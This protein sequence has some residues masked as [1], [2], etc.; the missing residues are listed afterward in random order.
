MSKKLALRYTQGKL[1]HELIPSEFKEA[2]AKVYTIGAEK[3]T[4][5]DEEGKVLEDGSSNW[6]KGL[7]W[8]QTLGAIYRHLEKFDRGEDFDYDFPPELLE[9][10]G[11]TYHLANAAW[12][13]AT[14]ITQYKTHPELD[15]RVHNYLD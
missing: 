7:S 5:R 10:Y 11:S 1:R 3:Y 13:L 12:G 15:D 4:I 2:L 8:K 6:R 9:K 14:L